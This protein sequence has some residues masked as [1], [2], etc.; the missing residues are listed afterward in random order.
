M[1]NPLGWCAGP[2]GEVF[3]TDNQGEWVATNKL[4]HV[5]EGRVLRLPQPGPAATH[6]EARR[7]D[8]GLGAVRAGHG[9]STASP[10]TT[11][12]ASSGRSPGSSSW[13]S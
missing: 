3:F 10:T 12:A 13:P 1:R 6:R 9:R 11:P 4:C 2:D 8:D 7:Q 5:A